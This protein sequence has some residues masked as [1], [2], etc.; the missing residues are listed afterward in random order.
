[1]E[2]IASQKKNLFGLIFVLSLIVAIFYGCAPTS[3][4]AKSPIVIPPTSTPTK[5]PIDFSAMRT[6]PENEGVVFGRIKV[7]KDGEPFN[8]GQP[9][10][11]T[12]FLSLGSYIEGDYF[13]VFVKEGATQ[14]QFS[15][16]LTEGGSFYW[17]LPPGNYNITGYRFA[18]GT[19]HIETELPPEAIWRF[20]LSAGELAYVGTLKTEIGKS[21]VVEDEYDQALRGL[22]DKFTEIKVEPVKRL[23]K[24]K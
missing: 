7:L 10:A 15:Y 16:I 11:V 3:P 20:T 24:S 8:W 22:K 17:H 13:T 23:L 5:S 21:G 14:K 12:L 9:K 18:T 1:M 6:I 2:R 4:T 19:K